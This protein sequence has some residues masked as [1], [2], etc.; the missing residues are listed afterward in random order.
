MHTVD[1]SKSGLWH[2]TLK[3]S[4]EKTHEDRVDHKLTW[5]FRMQD[6]V[7]SRFAGSKK[8]PRIFQI[9]GFYLVS[10][11]PPISDC[12]MFLAAKFSWGWKFN[13]PFFATQAFQKVKVSSWVKIWFCACYLKFVDIFWL[14]CL[15]QNRWLLAHNSDFPYVKW[16]YIL[17]IVRAWYVHSNGKQCL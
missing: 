13:F 3:G 16:N 11:K 17:H 5:K 10:F 7:M 9:Y 12:S 4:S 15:G 2:N 14:T 8:M 6:K 1:V